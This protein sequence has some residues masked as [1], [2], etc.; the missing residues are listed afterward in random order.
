[1][2][3]A[4]FFDRDG[5]LTIPVSMNGKGFA[6][7]CLEDF[8]YYEDAVESLQITRAAGFLN[9]VVSNQ[10]DVSTGLL[11]DSVLE[12]MN[13]RML[14][15]LELDEVNNCPHNSENN[16]SCRKPKPGM[17]KSSAERLGI[18]LSKSWIVG[19]RD[20]D[21][22]AG[23]IAGLRTVF[24][25]R[26]WIEESGSSAEFRCLSLTE[27]VSLILRHSSL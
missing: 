19:D 24:I 26:K 27:A 18:D 5:V 9:V 12:S 13:N 6:P 1:M 4:I 3:S 21:I 20:G 2:K 15:D 14:Q 16:C 22:T 25:D 10:P 11:L 17:I 7:R 8:K 23:S